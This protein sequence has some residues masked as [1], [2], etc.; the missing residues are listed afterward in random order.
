MQDSRSKR[1]G[2]GRRAIPKD[3]MPTDEAFK[4]K[5]ANPHAKGANKRRKLN[6]PQQDISP[7]EELATQTVI[8]KLLEFLEETNPFITEAP[9]TSTSVASMPID[10]TL[11]DEQVTLPKA[12]VHLQQYNPNQQGAQATS[13]LPKTTVK[14]SHCGI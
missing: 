11:D 1:F 13:S 7:E 5:S 14:I 10:S 8:R 3:F 12:K 2:A 9:L 6:N 4:S